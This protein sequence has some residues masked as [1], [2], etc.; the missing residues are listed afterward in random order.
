[1]KRLKSYI[2]DYHYLG[3]TNPRGELQHL[4]EEEA[5][6]QSIKLWIASFKGDAIR[7]PAR[8]GHVNKLFMQ[9]MKADDEDKVTMAIRDGLF[10]DFEPH[11]EIVVLDVTPNLED[12]YWELYMEVYS[13][14]LKV[15]TSVNERIKA[16]L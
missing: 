1:M 10:Q 15:K 6:N 4:W 5:L 14:T 7:K 3:Y 11:L 12:R 16:G 13:P 9:P 2:F 8:G